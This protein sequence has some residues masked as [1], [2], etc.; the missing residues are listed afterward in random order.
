[1]HAQKGAIY[2]ALVTTDP[3]HLVD[4]VVVECKVE[5]AGRLPTSSP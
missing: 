1:M 4:D 5:G 3:V 2:E